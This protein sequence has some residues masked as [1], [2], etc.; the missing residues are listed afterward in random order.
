MVDAARNQGLSKG[1]TGTPE[2]ISPAWGVVNRSTPVSRDEWEPP[3]E[4]KQGEKSREKKG[5][6]IFTWLK[7][8][9]GSAIGW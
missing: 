7:H 8:N 9:V 4:K 1:P 5:K 3:G 6:V 2:K